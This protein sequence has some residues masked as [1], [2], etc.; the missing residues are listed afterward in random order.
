MNRALIG[1]IVSGIFIYLSLKD[2]NYKVVVH[3]FKNLN[4]FFCL[5][6]LSATILTAFLRSIRLGIIISPVVKINQKGLFP[7]ICT[8]NMFNILLPLRIGEVVRAYL[9]SAKG[10]VP[11]SSSIAMIFL[12]RLLDLFFILVVLG[13][14]FFNIYLPAWVVSTGYSFFIGFIVLLFP[15]FFLCYR[16]EAILNLLKPLTK[17]L[18]KRIKDRLEA[19][20][21]TFIDG[22]GIVRSKKMIFYVVVLTAGIWALTGLGLYSMFFILNLQLPLIC[23]YVIMVLTA[24]GVSIPIAPG[25][26]GN[27]HYANILALSL[28]NMPKDIALAYSVVS[29]LL[30]ICIILLLGIIFLPAMPLS[31]KEINAQL[32]YR[33][34]KDSANSID[35]NGF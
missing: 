9:I 16:S 34:T 29:Y 6:G 4:Y 12:E 21:Q 14:V 8:G 2:V 20:I 19:Y 7:V 30:G 33:N 28:F 31:I 23:A 13:L 10:N 32:R 15:I 27:F 3:Q 26:I 25:Y 35:Q 18:P 11:L 1:I 22:L 24:L 5:P 17:R